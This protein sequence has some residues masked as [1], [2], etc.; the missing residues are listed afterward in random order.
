MNKLLALTNMELKRNSKFYLVYLSILSAIMLGLN[1][2]Q[3]NR[4]QDRFSMVE[5]IK[6]S[7]DGIFYGISIIYNNSYLHNIMGLSIIGI[8]IYSIYTWVREYTQNSVYTLKMIPCN[9]FNLYLSK[10]VSSIVMIYGVLITQITILFI[11][12]N[13]FNLMF[14]NTGIIPTSLFEDLSYLPSTLYYNMPI[15]LIDFI[16]IY[17]IGLILKLSILFTVI[18]FIIS[19]KSKNRRLFIIIIGLCLIIL[20]KIMTYENIGNF[21]INLGLEYINNIGVDVIVG[22]ILTILLGY[23]SYIL[24]N[25]K[26]YI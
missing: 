6:D 16:M 7:F 13:I 18:V 25:K 19:L 14:K 10:M 15:N 24:I 22:T 23:I 4:F 17:G 5:K 3:I 11:S 1:I 26:F 21:Y 20:N 12:K 2:I 8:F 9:K